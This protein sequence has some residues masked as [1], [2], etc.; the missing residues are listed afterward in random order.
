MVRVCLYFSPVATV[1]ED[2]PEENRGGTA[3]C[4]AAPTRS[5]VAHVVELVDTMALGAIERRPLAR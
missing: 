3:V 1:W 2:E 5:F 4:S